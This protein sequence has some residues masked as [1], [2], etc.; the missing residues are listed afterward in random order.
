MLTLV[1]ENVRFAVISTRMEDSLAVS[2]LLDEHERHALDALYLEWYKH[3]S[4]Q[5]ESPQPNVAELPGV[6]VLKNVMRWRYLTNRIILHRPTLLWYSMRKITWD[7][8]CE[9]KRAAIELC[10]ELSAELIN[11]IAT[12]WRAQKACQMSGW[13]ATWILYQAAMVPLLS[14]YSDPQNAE[15]VEQSRHQVETTTGILADLQNWSTTA[16]RSLEVVLRLWEGSRKHGPELL[17]KQ[18]TCLPGSMDTPTSIT[19][20]MPAPSSTGPPFK[21]TYI[22]VSFANTFGSDQV[23]NTANQEM[24]MDNMFDSLNWSNSWDSPIGGPQM[25]N[26]WDYN[27]MQNWAGIQLTDEYFDTGFS[28]DPQHLQYMDIHPTSNPSDVMSYTHIDHSHRM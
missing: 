27:S 21:P 10:R 18:D 3:S 8:L 28:E 24:F 20:Q 22:D 9:E 7:K 12:T 23:L 14:L 2:P 6:T 17:D 11:D 13:N 16:K 5:Y 4:V 26:R 15:V 1:Q 19:S 25:M